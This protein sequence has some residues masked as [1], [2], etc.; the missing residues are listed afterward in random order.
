[1]APPNGVTVKLDNP[2]RRTAPVFPVVPAIPLTY[3]QRP[4]KK[5][6]PAPPV[7]ASSVQNTAQEAPDPSIPNGHHERQKADPMGPEHTSAGEGRDT[8][9]PSP[10]PPSNSD[11]V[12]S[13]TSS[14]VLTPPTVVSGGHAEGSIPHPSALPLSQSSFR[15]APRVAQTNSPTSL[16]TVSAAPTPHQAPGPSNPISEY[17]PVLGPAPGLP[18]PAPQP[19]VPNRPAFHQVHPSNGGVVSGVFP[20]SNEHPFQHPNHFRAAAHHQYPGHPAA[21]DNFSMSHINHSNH[22]GP[23]TPHSFQGSQSSAQAEEQSYSRHPAMNARSSYPAQRMAPPPPE[24]NY[25]FQQEETM[26]FLRQQYHDDALRDCYL[27]VQFVANKDFWDHPEYSRLDFS[28]NFPG[29][30]LMFARSPLLMGVMK[31]QGMKERIQLRVSD[32]YVRPDVFRYV[33]DTLYGWYWLDRPFPSGLPYRDPRDEFKTALSYIS[34]ARY[35]RLGSLEVAAAHRASMLLDWATIETAAR[36]ISESVI[37]SAPA[38]SSGS[39]VFI[40]AVVGWLARNFPSNFVIDIN[41]GNSGFPRLPPSLSS[42]LRKGEAHSR[43][44]SKAKVQMP[45][46][47]RIPSNPRLSLISF[48]EIPSFEDQPSLPSLFPNTGYSQAPRPEHTILSRIL[49]NL[50]FEIL[51]V[52]VEHPYL[53]ELQGEYA[54]DQRLAMVTKIIEAREALRSRAVDK[55]NEQL[56]LFHKRLETASKDAEVLTKEDHWVNTMGF[57]E[58]V[59]SG[60]IPFLVRTWTVG[61]SDSGLS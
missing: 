28:L 57:K 56:E 45:R 2:P 8:N 1:M 15:D 54:R 17:P 61:Q 6:T 30:R 23:P 25:P 46:D 51:K 11:S 3:T 33:L 4:V 35:L 24:I 13:A 27:S 16:N 38:A 50:P 49:L 14:A 19:F 37:F 41:A 39:M 44:P 21:F 52:V 48:G 43:Q 10:V 36:F 42:P 40:N 34:T 47:S 31:Q 20:E 18:L 9:T 26:D 58:E 60:D 7:V 22:H 12:Q 59:F 55:T 29:H 53:A 5:Q 32:E